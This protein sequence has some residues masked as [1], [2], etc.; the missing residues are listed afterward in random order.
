ME[1]EFRKLRIR[2]GK[3]A[4]HVLHLEFLLNHQH[5]QRN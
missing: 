1:L 4:S 2:S 5:Q 3:D